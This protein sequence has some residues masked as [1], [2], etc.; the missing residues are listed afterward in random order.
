MILRQPLSDINKV[1]H[2]CK[3]VF[4]R[5]NLTTNIR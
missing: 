4:S 5:F 2:V 1:K 3:M